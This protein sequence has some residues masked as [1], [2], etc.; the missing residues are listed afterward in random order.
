M[1]RE[2]LT[3]GILSRPHGIVS[4]L[5]ESVLTGGVAQTT[6]LAVNLVVGSTSASPHKAHAVN[7]LHYSLR[8]LQKKPQKVLF[9]AGK[10]NSEAHSPQISS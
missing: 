9:A 4:S 5:D 8:H 2:R 3:P 10:R 6:E 1:D 7:R